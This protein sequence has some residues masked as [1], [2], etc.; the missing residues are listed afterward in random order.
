MANTYLVGITLRAT[1]QASSVI[2]AVKNP[3]AGLQVGL[4]AA[5]RSA[6]T[7]DQQW[8]AL[9][10]T[11]TSVG[12]ALSV[13]SG[14]VLG[15][16]GLAGKAFADAEEGS[17]NLTAIIGGN[18]Q[19]LIDNA[20]AIEQLTKFEDDAIVSATAVGATFMGLRDTLS[21]AQV[22]AVN[23]SQ[24]YGT[25]LST[26]MMMLGK[27]S[28]GQIGAL[29]RV[30]IMVDAS[31]FK[32]RGMQAV[33]EE[34]GKEFNNAAFTASGLAKAFG[35]AKNAIGNMAEAVGGALAPGLKIIG[36]GLK[37]VSE[38]ATAF[39]G[40][41][42]GQAMVVVGSGA[43]IAAGSV[44]ALLL[45]GVKVAQAYHA[46]QA[47][48]LA[49]G[50]TEI[51][52]QVAAKAVTAAMWLQSLSV[53][54]IVVSLRAANASMAMTGAASVGLAAKQGLAA[55]G[56]WLLNAG[57]KALS[58]QG[59]ILAGVFRIAW[60][61]LFGPIGIIV[62]GIAAIS[63]AVWFLTSRHRAAQKAAEEQSATQKQLAEEGKL[64]TEKA[65]AATDEAAT[66]AQDAADAK[67]ALAD[68]EKEYNR[69]VEDQPRT[70]RDV[71]NSLRDAKEAVV[72]AQQGIAEQATDA[73]EKVTDAQQ[74]IADAHEDAAKTARTSA[75]S[76]E[77]AE[78]RLADANSD[79]ADR[80]E[81][82]MEGVEDSY[83]RAEKAA[84]NLADVERDSD[85]AVDKTEKRA[86]ERIEDAQERLQDLL[87]KQ[88]GVEETPEQRMARDI[89]D[90]REELA[91]AETEGSQEI[92]DARQ[93][94]ADAVLAAQEQLADAQ[95]AVA[96]AEEA[97]VKAEVDGR[98]AIADAERALADAR[99][100]AAEAEKAAAERVQKAEEALTKARQENEK[101][102]HDAEIRLRNATEAYVRAAEDAP[103]K[104]Q[105]AADAIVRAANALAKA[106]Q[107][108]A[109][110]TATSAK[111][112]ATAEK[113][114]DPV[115]A[116]EEQIKRNQAKFRAFGA[117]NFAGQAKAQREWDE[118]LAQM[119]AQYGEAET[120]RMVAEAVKRAHA[121]AAGGPVAPGSVYLVGERGPEL[122]VP[123]LAGQIV[124][125]MAAPQVPGGAGGGRQ[126]VNVFNFNAPLYG[127]AGIREVARDVLTRQIAA[128]RYS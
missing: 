84:R 58:V 122:F 123:A 41:P 78:R 9:A 80:V 82:A 50:E 115:T 90:A 100:A 97:R 20:S 40:T 128:A 65:A 109:G 92:A 19:A 102:R 76:I 127:E 11:A 39:I 61:A 62:A 77:D 73:A 47:A 83:K 64:A 2:A 88:A 21:Q 28:E 30:G 125:N 118:T 42:I 89:A 32:A 96:K 70:A 33:Y 113:A 29:R 54:G 75:R 112:T 63:A 104:L 34:I 18:S 23:I 6:S 8:G 74:D 43:V 95:D 110:K 60:A 31:A 91:K 93:S 56:S 49:F 106:R 114:T 14:A 119:R 24:V 103:R 99:V 55:A 52:M 16:L 13:A 57:L 15:A 12:T 22:A 5:R 121:R 44:G 1:D 46:A 68:A 71:A 108:A 94:A 126:V 45:V 4:D 81:D 124:P 48:L 85:K 98:R 69:A 36:S 26:A 38:A 120:E 3:L 79:A 117:F 87:N 17:A 107:E 37:A 7:F 35:Q 66:A 67:L 27:A 10:G 53:D 101:A 72:D 105:D 51:G 116:L 25:D 59:A 111:A 86:A